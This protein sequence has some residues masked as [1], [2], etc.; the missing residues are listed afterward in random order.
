MRVAPLLLAFAT[1]FSAAS[2]ASAQVWLNADT[3]KKVNQSNFR[4]LEDWPAPSDLAR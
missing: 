2:Y 1:T 3:A 4:A